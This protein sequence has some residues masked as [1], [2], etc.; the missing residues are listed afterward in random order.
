MGFSPFALGRHSVMNGIGVQGGALPEVQRLQIE[1]LAEFADGHGRLRAW[2]NQEYRRL[3]SRFDPQADV[4]LRV[5]QQEWPPS[6]VAS[7]DAFARLIGP[8]HL[9]APQ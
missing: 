3:A 7:R 5:W 4:P 6:L 8:E 9:P 1:R 2:R